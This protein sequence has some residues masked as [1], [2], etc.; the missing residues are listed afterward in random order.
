MEGQDQMELK[1]SGSSEVGGLELCIVCGDRASGRHYGAISCE[2][3]KGFFKRSIRKKLGYQ[4]RGSMNCE[5]TKHHRNRC[6][7]CRLQKCLACGMRSDSVQHERKPIVDKSKGE[8][9][10]G[11]HDRQAAYSKFLGLAGQAQAGQ[12]NPKE[13]PS[14][15]FGAVSPAPAINFA[16]AAAVAFNKSNPVSPY[17]TP[18]N[19]GDIEGARRQQF[20]LQTQLAKN[21]FKMGQFGAINEY[22]QSAYGATPPEVPLGALHAAGDAQPNDVEAGILSTPESVQLCVSLPGPAPGHLRLHAVC[23][24][25]ARLLAAAAR[26]LRAV[27]AAHAL[28]FEIQVTLLKKCWPELFVLCLSM[29][30]VQLSLGTLLP[31]L[32]AHLQTVL[33]D[34]TSND[35]IDR[36]HDMAAPEI[37]AS[38]YSDERIA[39]VTSSLSRLQQFISHM[40]QLR[41][42]QR[43]HAHLRALCLFSPDGVPDFLTRKLQDYQIKVLRSLRATCQDEDRLATLLLQLPVLRTFSGPFLEDVFFV[44]FVGDVSIDDVIPYL[45][46]TER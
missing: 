45:L 23:E 38:D 4:C 19:A 39:E 10:E 12:I 25:G 29:F 36:S 15:A 33:R 5:V 1:F 22:L 35:S 17:L 14:D 21:L 43:E 18:G 16:L 32:V 28:P 44:G 34:R 27:P 40:E 13:E 46:N 30:S 8:Q 42:Q 20:M 11:I 6:Q 26:W 2:G 31:Q 24:A 41:L 7:Y 37:S 3:C 9:R